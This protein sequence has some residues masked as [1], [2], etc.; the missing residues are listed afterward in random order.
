MELIRLSRIKKEFENP[1]KHK[2]IVLS[3]INI[4]FQDKGF[5]VIEGQSGAGKSTLIKIIAQIIEPTSGKYYYQNNILSSDSRQRSCFRNQQVGLLFQDY[6]LIDNLN[7]LENVILPCLISGE[8]LK[9][10]SLKAYKLFKC[11][12]LESKMNSF[13]NELS[14]GEK[15][16]VSFLRSLINE[17]TFYLCDEPTGALD[18]ENAHLLLK[19]LKTLSQTKLVIVV[20]HNPVVAQEYADYVYVLKDGELYEK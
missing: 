7:S 4:S 10:A 9:V 11:I 16:R 19:E 13:I 1:F 15:Q 3:N 6:Q 14:G 20:T 2:Q 5:Y 8:S 18:E 12:N 17:P